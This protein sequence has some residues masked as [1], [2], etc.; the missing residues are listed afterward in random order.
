MAG[1]GFND[2]GALAAANIGVAVGSGDQVNLEAAD[3]LI[4]GD[5][6]RAIVRLLELAKRTRMI[7]NVNIAISIMITLL[8]VSA[9]IA[10]ENTSMAIGIAIHEASVFLVIIN[11]MF[12]SSSNTGRINVLL[13]L[14]K[15]LVK[16]L[17]EAFV[18]LFRGNNTTA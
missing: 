8:L 5:D 6:P 17:K 14:M 10:G 9:T 1:D 15:G 11:G 4:P 18:V 2:A 3:V 16:D 13:D 7:V 12:V